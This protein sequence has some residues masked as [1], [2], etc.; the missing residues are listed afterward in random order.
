MSKLKVHVLGDEDV[1]R[2]LNEKYSFIDKSDK[3]EI[4]NDETKAHFFVVD[5]DRPSEEYLDKIY[6]N[7]SKKGTYMPVILTAFEDGSL[8]SIRSLKSSKLKSLPVCKSPQEVEH[9]LKMFSSL[10]YVD[11]QPIMKQMASMVQQNLCGHNI[12]SENGE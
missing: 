3:F 4:E 12:L 7:F 8:N 6:F 2:K 11:I 1:N 9:T 10:F 5:F